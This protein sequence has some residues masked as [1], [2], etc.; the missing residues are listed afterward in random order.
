MWDDLLR[1]KLTNHGRAAARAGLSRQPGGKPKNVLPA[2]SVTRTESMR[3]SRSPR[4]W[5]D[6]GTH[7]FVS[8]V[9]SPAIPINDG[10]I[11]SQPH[12]GR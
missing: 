9:V 3:S 10:H 12:L 2:C 1:V 5:P 8:A 7:S 4:E 11:P 6:L